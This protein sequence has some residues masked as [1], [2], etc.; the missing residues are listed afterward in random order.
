V[1]TTNRKTL[2]QLVFCQGCCCGRVDRGKPELPV[3]LLKTTWK[4]EKLNAAVQLTI[5]G[6]LGPCDRTNVT[7][8]M[9]PGGNTWLGD[10][11]GEATYAA[12]IEWAR[13]CKRTGELQPLPAELQSHEFERF[14]A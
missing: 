6:C 11:Q 1:S 14:P 4:A 7:L 8:V 3:E 5:S 10:L 9:S 13:A 2:A 12:M